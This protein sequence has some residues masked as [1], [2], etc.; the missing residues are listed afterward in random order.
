MASSKKKENMKVYAKKISKKN[1][2]SNSKNNIKKKTKKK[3]TNKKRN[4]KK[5]TP[6]ITPIVKETVNKVEPLESVSKIQKEEKKPIKKKKVKSN[7]TSTKQVKRKKDKPKLFKSISNVLLKIIKIIKSI[8]KK[9]VKNKIVLLIIGFSVLA[10]LVLILVIYRTPKEILF[11]FK[12]YNIG[13]KVKLSDDS[14]WYVVKNSTISESDVTLLSAKTLDVN[15]DGKIDEKDKYVFDEDGNC[16][17]DEK[18]K[19][20]IG[21]FLKNDAKKLLDNI[22]NI[23]KI[24]LLTSDEYIE[25]RKEMNFGYDWN[26]GNWLANK[27]LDSWWLETS[28]YNSIYTVTKKGS[29][30]L[31]DAK[32]KNYIRLVIEISKS[33]IK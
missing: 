24:R 32:D 12:S 22:K 29:Y 27:E 23:D 13:D 30:K 6:K 18:N 31:S 33:S 1:N 19:K 2:H 16:T 21:Y 20:N 9:I 15:K 28:K 26:E 11:Q 7:N 8:L 25:V 5:V 4:I 3:N 17:Y 10:A 14:E